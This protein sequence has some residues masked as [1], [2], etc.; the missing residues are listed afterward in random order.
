[1]LN[2][3]QKSRVFEV[4]F[5]SIHKLMLASML[6]AIARSVTTTRTGMPAFGPGA[7]AE[8]ASYRAAF[9]IKLSQALLW[10]SQ[11]LLLCTLLDPIVALTAQTSQLMRC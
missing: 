8:E 4:D 3:Q 5:S 1:L 10:L 9:K 7:K 11:S 6:F 2:Q